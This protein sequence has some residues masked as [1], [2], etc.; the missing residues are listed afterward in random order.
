LDLEFEQKAFPTKATE[1]ITTTV[2][3]V[4]QL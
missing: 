2:C 3:Y 4:S 1:R